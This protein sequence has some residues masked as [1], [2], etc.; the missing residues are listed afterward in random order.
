ML[1]R[2]LAAMVAFLLGVGL[3]VGCGDSAPTTAPLT[4]KQ[5]QK[6]QM[7]PSQMKGNKG[8]Y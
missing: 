1:S 6:E 5:K 4:E 2:R 7:K 8:K 3:V